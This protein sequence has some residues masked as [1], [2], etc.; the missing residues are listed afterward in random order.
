MGS[1]TAAAMAAL[2]ATL[3]L[4][5]LRRVG[6]AFDD[7]G[8]EVA[9]VGGT[10]RDAILGR[11]GTDFDFTTNATP[12][13]TL[14]VLRTLSH[15]QWETGRA[16]GTIGAKVDGDTVEV[17]TYRADAYAS[18]SRK[19]DVAF[20]TSLEAD[21]ERRDFSANAIA[22]R[23]PDGIIVDPYRGL[24]D[25]VE[26]VLRTP[27]SPKRS[28]SD[29]PL[30]M[31]RA[32]RFVSQLGWT[33]SQ[34]TR[35]AMVEQAE[36]IKI[37]SAERS[38]TEL[39]KLLLGAHPVDGLEVLVDTGLAEYILPELPALRLTIDAEHRHKDVYRHSLTVLQ[40]AI[41]QEPDGPDLVLRLAALLH[42]I[43]K[44]KTRRFG[45]DGKVTFRH[46]DVVGAKIAKRRLAA[47]R[48]DN[49]TIKAVSR[50]VELHMRFYGYGEA[51]WTDSAVRRYVRDAGDLL[52]R[53]HILTRAD[54]T[55]RNVRKAER[56]EH[57]YDDLER[58]IAELAEQE[59]L[60]AVRPELDGQAIMRILDIAP[61]PLVG[62]AYR[63]LL[64]VRLDEGEIGETAAEQRLRAWY[65][66][67]AQQTGEQ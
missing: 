55:T 57:A 33:I 15:T 61:G 35:A 50:L 64:N 60:D 9:I 26:G 29:D 52:P 11:P 22:V 65:V 32:A 27:G 37:V 4:P 34:E 39:E 67:R 40:Q 48:F 66:E 44:P 8:F 30:R 14:A 5:L 24:G 42:D 41:D 58:R 31:M 17:T 28:F 23:L 16:F 21:L 2:Q 62:E 13:E 19:P 46:H 25:I 49:H 43:G 1:T 12:D 18:D 6:D 63:Y 53:L 59:T 47:L 7:A 45:A 54:V 36:R 56:L 3:D 20:G 10:V 38:R 51:G